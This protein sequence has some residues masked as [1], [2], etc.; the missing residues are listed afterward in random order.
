[1]SE[2][3]MPEKAYCGEFE[4]ENMDDEVDDEW[5]RLASALVKP[6]EK[7]EKPTG[8]IRRKD[9]KPKNKNAG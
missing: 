9:A 2:Q 5:F 8:R 7:K 3:M 4:G 6:T 1:M